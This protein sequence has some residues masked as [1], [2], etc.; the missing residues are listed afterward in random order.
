MA[1]K[2]NIKQLEEYLKQAG[3]DNGELE[4]LL[5][6]IKELNNQRRYGLVWEE[7][8]NSSYSTDSAEQ[9]LLKK[10][11]FLKEVNEHRIFNGEQHP[12][13]LLIE[14]DNLHALKTL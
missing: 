13:H 7:P 9:E 4:N 1:N 2:I 5:N 8:D 3:L 12:D 14:G 6:P 10:F 11:P